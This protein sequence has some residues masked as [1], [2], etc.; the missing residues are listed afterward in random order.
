MAPVNDTPFL[1]YM[2]Q[3]LWH[4]KITHIILSTGYL[5]ESIVGYFGDNFRGIPLTYIREEEPMGTGGAIRMAMEACRESEAFVLNGDSFFDIDLELFARM[6]HAAGAQ[7]SIALREVGNASRYGTVV[8]D[9]SGRIIR[10]T[11]KSADDKPGLINGGVYL[12]QK[13]PYMESMPAM[14]PFSI[15]KDF[16]AKKISEQIIAAFEFKGY[17]IDIGIPADYAKAQDELKG[18]KYR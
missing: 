5:S 15:E 2:L 9:K 8:T 10:F 4:A 1:E 18:F 12:L 3:Y 11:E 7:F 6:H 16:F 17:F 14:V 13:K